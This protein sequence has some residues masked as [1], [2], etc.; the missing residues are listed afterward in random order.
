MKSEQAG[1]CKAFTISLSG[2]ELDPHVRV[3][4]LMNAMNRGRIWI[5]Y[6]YFIGSDRGLLGCDTVF[7]WDKVPTFRRTLLPPCP[8]DGP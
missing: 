6:K 1:Y 8:E 5:D 7:W 2:F 4:Y 3:L